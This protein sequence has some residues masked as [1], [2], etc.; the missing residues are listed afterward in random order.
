MPE[1][2]RTQGIASLTCV[3]SPA[4][5]MPVAL[6]PNCNGTCIVS[7]F[8]H[9]VALLAWAPDDAACISYKF[10]H[11]MAPLEFSFKIGHQMAPLA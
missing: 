3:I 6:V 9:K 2:Q 5:S 4:K 7:N 11:Q 1:A 8:G 10:G